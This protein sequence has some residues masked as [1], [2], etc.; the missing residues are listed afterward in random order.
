MAAST[1]VTL[2]DL[3]FNRKEEPYTLRGLFEYLESKHALEL[4]D[5]WLAA[6]D[7][8]NMYEPKHE[9]S[10]FS[11]NRN[12]WKMEDLAAALGSEVGP[13]RKRRTESLEEVRQKT[14]SMIRGKLDGILIMAQELKRKHAEAQI[15]VKMTYVDDEAPLCINVSNEMRAQICT[16]CPVT[17][18]QDPRLGLF[19]A[20]M[21]ECE[22]LI[23]D[24]HLWGFLAACQASAAAASPDFPKPP[25]LVATPPPPRT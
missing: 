14:P 18:D 2:D 20:A 1:T 11:M 13:A 9:R 5:F 19:D 16:N 22:K 8:R 25:L 24:N 12:H 7:V 6:Q 15:L 17:E 23:T 4:L 21:D 3:L 10:S